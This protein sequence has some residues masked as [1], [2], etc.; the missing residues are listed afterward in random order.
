MSQSPDPSPLP[1]TRTMTT[2]RRLALTEFR[3]QV[4]I[5]LSVEERDAIRRL[6]PGIRI[7]PTLGFESCYDLTPDQRIG[8]V[9]LPNLVVEIRPKVPMSSVLFLIS[10]A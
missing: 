6:H 1:A 10:Y 2:V 9:C 3:T 7:E 4:A 5:A 8:I